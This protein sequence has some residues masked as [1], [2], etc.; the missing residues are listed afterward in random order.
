MH[1]LWVLVISPKASWSPIS[2]NPIVFSDN[3]EVNIK[4]IWRKSLLEVYCDWRKLFSSDKNNVKIKIKKSEFVAD[5]LIEN[6]YVDLWDNKI[7]N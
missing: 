3:N 7:F 2:Q 1:D 5:F 4:N 6:S